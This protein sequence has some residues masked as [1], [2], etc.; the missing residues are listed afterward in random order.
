MIKVPLVWRLRTG[1]RSRIGARR[2]WRIE[3]EVGESKRELEPA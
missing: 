1:S 2:T 3:K